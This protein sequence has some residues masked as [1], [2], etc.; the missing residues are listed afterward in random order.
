MFKGEIRE[1]SLLK[2]RPAGTRLKTFGGKSSGPEPGGREGAQCSLR[3]RRERT[4]LWRAGSRQRTAYRLRDWSA[5]LVE[6]D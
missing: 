5:S 6:K 2:L 3:A 4:A 1:F